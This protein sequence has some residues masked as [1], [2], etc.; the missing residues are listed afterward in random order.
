MEEISK[1]KV[2]RSYNEISLRTPPY[3]KSPQLGILGTSKPFP[4]GENY[5]HNVI[6]FQFMSRTLWLGPKKVDNGYSRFI[7]L[8]Y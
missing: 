3:M 7:I 6:A 4:P 1:V 5:I 8:V 2:P